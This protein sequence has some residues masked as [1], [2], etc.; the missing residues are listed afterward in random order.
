[1]RNASAEIFEGE[2]YNYNVIH[3]T[4]DRDEIRKELDGTE[5]VKNRASGYG[6]RVPWH[7]RV[8]KGSADDPKLAEKA[9]D[10]RFQTLSERCCG[11]SR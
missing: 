5:D 9:T 4:N 10:F 1:L 3:L 7:T 11:W 8:N 2:D 6:L